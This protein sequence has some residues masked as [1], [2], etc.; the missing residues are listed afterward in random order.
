MHVDIEQDGIPKTLE[1]F[2]TVVLASGMLPA[3]GPAEEIRSAVAKV[4]VIGDAINAGD[5]FSSTQAGYQL[6]LRY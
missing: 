5:I 1:S 4:E 3:E 6:A 2:Q